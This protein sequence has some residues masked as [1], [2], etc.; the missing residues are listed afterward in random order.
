MAR[1]RGV[2]PQCVAL[3]SSARLVS[4]ALGSDTGGSIRGPAHFCGVTGLKT[5]YGRVSR[6][7]AMPLSFTLDST[8][9]LKSGPSLREAIAAVDDRTG[10][11]RPDFYGINCSHPIE[12][13][14]ALEPG[15]WMLRLRSL[16]PNA[17]KMNKISLCTLGHLESGDPFELGREMGEL[18]RRY[19][20]LDVW[21]GCCGTWETHLDEIAQ[22]VRLAH[23]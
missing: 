20:H 16:R 13:E 23:N 14:P 1:S 10:S 18:A 3:T 11:A 22:Q 19:P 4:A 7:N 6:A 12:F 15:D 5:S 9:R 17:A 21:G 2:S 8:S